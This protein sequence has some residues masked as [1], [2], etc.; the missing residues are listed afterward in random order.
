[1]RSKK[2]EAC[3]TLLDLAPSPLLSTS[4]P[5]TQN[6]HHTAPLAHAQLYFYTLLFAY[7]GHAWLYLW[8]LF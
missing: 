1:M 8:E 4:V 5:I 6:V 2:E 3:F 7:I